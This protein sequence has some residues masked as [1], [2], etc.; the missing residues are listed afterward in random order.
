VQR[1]L[2]A[3]AAPAMA[4][5]SWSVLAD[6]LGALGESAPY[7]TAADVFAA[8][9]QAHSDFSGLSYDRLGLRGLPVLNAE[10]AAA[11]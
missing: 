9:A 11:S 6:L 7:Y 8:L 10:P 1:F 5:P 4:R 2:Q 3:K